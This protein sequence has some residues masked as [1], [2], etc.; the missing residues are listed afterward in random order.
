MDLNALPWWAYL[1]IFVGVWILLSV[2]D[3]FGPVFHAARDAGIAEALFEHRNFY[4]CDYTEPH[5]WIEYK[6]ADV[7]H[8][9]EVSIVTQ[10]EPGVI[11]FEDTDGRSFLVHTDE[12]REINVPVGLEDH[13]D[14]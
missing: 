6:F 14:E 2:L 10:I 13:A 5:R 1:L 4:S 3:F 12:W 9:A 7:W 11:A 8:R